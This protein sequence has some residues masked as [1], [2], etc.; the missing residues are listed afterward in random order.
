[1]KSVTLIVQGHISHERYFKKLVDTLEAIQCVEKVEI[2][3]QEGSSDLLWTNTIEPFLERLNLTSFKLGVKRVGY[4]QNEAL[5]HLLKPG[6]KALSLRSMILP[7]ATEDFYCPTLNSLSHIAVYANGLQ[8]LVLGLNTIYST[9]TLGQWDAPYITRPVCHLLS[10]WKKLPQS[11]STLQFLRIKEL[12]NPPSFT[13]QEYNDIAQLLDIM[14]PRLVSIR[15]YSDVDENEPY[16]KDHWWFIEHLR[17]MYKE[18]R[19]YRPAH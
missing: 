9:D 15:P 3:D 13:I 12:K 17:L 2:L 1:M 8:T 4:E 18:L 5:G 6:S 7:D 11:Q 10:V 19:M 16:W 14:F